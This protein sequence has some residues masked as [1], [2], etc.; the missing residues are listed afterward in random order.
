MLMHLIAPKT[1]AVPL[2]AF[3]NML[4]LPV[5]LFTLQGSSLI[6]TK[7][8][9]LKGQFLEA[10]RVTVC[11]DRVYV[12]DGFGYSIRIY[13]L[14][15]LLKKELPLR[16]GSGPGEFKNGPSW[17]SC[18]G[19]LVAVNDLSTPRIMLYDRDL[20]YL[21]EFRANSPGVTGVYIDRAGRV[22]VATWRGDKSVIQSFSTK[23][24][25][26]KEFVVS[27]PNPKNAFLNIC[28]FG[29]LSS[30]R[31]VVV[32][33]F[34]NRFKVLSKGGQEIM[35]G[36]VP[37]LPASLSPDA[38]SDPLNPPLSNVVQD[39]SASVDGRFWLLSGTVARQPRRELFLYDHQGKLVATGIVPEA[40]YSI[41]AYR[42][43]L[44]FGIKGNRTSVSIYRIKIVH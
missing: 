9:E 33:P 29:V 24:E 43:G 19:D 8:G 31:F 39:V 37:G 13:S 17:I 42:D 22:Y 38:F 21:R 32:S 12:T 26:L 44:L 3:Y 25:F 4:M 41:T 5:I 28:K 10:V 36:N 20:N 7:V 2:R 40:L 23:G 30:D 14:D 11:S 15:G 6:V 16:K 27:G 34:S 1:F 18:N 35:T